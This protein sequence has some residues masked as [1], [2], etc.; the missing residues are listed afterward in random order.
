MT[1]ATVTLVVLAAGTYALKAT[2]PFVLSGRRTLPLWAARVAA[3]VP[4]AL[5]AA[6]AATGTFVTDEELVLDARVPGVIAAGIALKM[7]AP[8]VV[9]V[10]LAAATT[11]LTRALADTM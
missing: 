9:V 4:A 1:A 5:L 11:A 3:L 10:L 2:G 6:M 8:F 7:K